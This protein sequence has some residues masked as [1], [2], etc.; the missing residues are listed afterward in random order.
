MT[1]LD[2]RVSRWLSS[3]TRHVVHGLRFVHPVKVTLEQEHATNQAIARRRKL[4]IDGGNGSQVRDQRSDVNVTHVPV[5]ARGHEG[6]CLPTGTDP[7]PD[8]PQEVV[9]GAIGG[10]S[11]TS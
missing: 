9:V 4:P 1:V 3:S 6:E 11:A 8:G 10:D 7:V 5:I 2:R